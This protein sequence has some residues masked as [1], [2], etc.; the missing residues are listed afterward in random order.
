MK[1]DRPLRKRLKYGAI[2]WLV[3]FMIFVANLFPR[4]I[5]LA[6]CGSL[7]TL[8]Y[9]LMPGERE[10]TVRHLSMAFGK[11]KGQRE[12][13]TMARNVFRMLGINGGEIL[14]AVAI[15]N[16]EQLE[17]VLVT[18]GYDNFEKAFARGKGVIFVTCHVGAFEIQVT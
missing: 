15:R 18:H 17:Q 4:K 5:W 9:Y 6:L 13:N 7:G 16:M 10:K 11:E 3:R 2:Y 12:I 14:R 1:D 8:G